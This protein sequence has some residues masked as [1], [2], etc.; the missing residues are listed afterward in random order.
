MLRVA[1]SLRS[2]SDDEQRSRGGEAED[3]GRKR[4]ETEGIGAERKGS[5]GNGAERSGIEMTV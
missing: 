3:N 4:K 1:R 2:K 5:E